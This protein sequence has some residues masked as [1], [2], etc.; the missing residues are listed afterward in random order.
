MYNAGGDEVIQT[1]VRQGKVKWFNAS[2]GYGFIDI[3]DGLDVFVHHSQIQA[4]GYRALWEGEPV[5]F[6]MTDGPKGRQATD[7]VPTSRIR[8]ADE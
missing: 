2:K 3:G 7:V 1:D 4:E 6:V 8:A 5:S